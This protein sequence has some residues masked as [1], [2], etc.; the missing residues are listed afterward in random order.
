MTYCLGIIT[1]HGIVLSSDSRTNAGHDQI[2]VTRKMHF[3]A[4]PGQRVFAL[5][6]SGSLSCSQSVLTML[7]QQFDAGEGLASVTSMY[8]AARVVGD[9]VRTVG[10]IDRPAL[11]RDGFT[12]NVNIILG[13]QIRGERPALYLIYPQGNPLQA[14]D[15]CPYL[16]IGEVK[17]GRPILDRAIR[18]DTTTLEDAA[19]LALVSMDSTMKS[20]VTVGPPVDLLAYPN[21]DLAFRNVRRFGADD[22]DLAKIRSRW[23]GALRQAVLKLPGIRFT[24]G[25]AASTAAGNTA[26]TA[27]QTRTIELVEPAADTAEPASIPATQSA[28]KPRQPM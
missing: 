9:A 4:T 3:I 2:N 23:E 11:E 10:D 20:N 13:G 22:P 6:T 18:F 25:K 19:K 28:P 12:F 1:K 16:Q 14:T 15:D 27:E 8:E 7:K 24:S 21:D 26:A 5:C 17:Y